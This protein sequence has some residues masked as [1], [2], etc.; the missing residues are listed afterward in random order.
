MEFEIIK[1]ISECGAFGISILLIFY[2]YK[3]D[4]MFNKT[5]NNHLAHE[6][7]SRDKLTVAL[8]KLTD[9]LGGCPHNTNK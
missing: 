3:K 1:A 5:M 2:I 4:Q 9:K 8:T 7:E 6:T